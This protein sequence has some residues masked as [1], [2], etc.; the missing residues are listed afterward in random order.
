MKPE[1]D[2]PAAR[3]HATPRL[4]GMA[5]ALA[6]AYVLVLQA[7]LGGVASGAH[8]AGG[9]TVDAYG[10][11]LCLGSSASAPSPADPS[12]H[13]PDCC[14]TGCNMSAGSALPPPANAALAAPSVQPL[15]TAL[16]RTPRL[17]LAAARSPRHTR[18]PPLA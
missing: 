3:K 11:V 6:L 14:T 18:A 17:A 7:L 16:P 15:R 12:H 8:A 1:D 2:R 9:V 13:A 10:Q 4:R 5:M